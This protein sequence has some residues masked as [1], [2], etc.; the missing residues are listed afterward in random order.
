[1][2]SGNRE[3]RAVGDGMAGRRMH[4]SAIPNGGYKWLSQ[5]D[6]VYSSGNL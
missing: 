4:E 6:K 3:Q 5:M 2:K 1:M